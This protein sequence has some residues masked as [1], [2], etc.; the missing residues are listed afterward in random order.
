M[1][2][3]LLCACKSVAGS[4]WRGEAPINWVVASRGLN[5]NVQTPSRQVVGLAGGRPKHGDE[6][7]MREFGGRSSNLFWRARTPTGVA[8]RF[9]IADL[10][11]PLRPLETA[12]SEVEGWTRDAMSE[13][14]TTVP[15]T[16]RFDDLGLKR[17]VNHSGLSIEPSPNGVVL[18]LKHAE[19]AYRIVINQAFVSPIAG[20]IGAPSSNRLLVGPG[21]ERRSAS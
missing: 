14:P 16:P 12:N 13:S 19:G 7:H 6:T 5:A 21:S 20:G 17:I 9:E 11:S 10:A 3:N 15:T 4:I 1:L 18:S 8:T 2:C